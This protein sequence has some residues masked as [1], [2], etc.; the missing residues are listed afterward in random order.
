MNTSIASPFFD[1][2]NQV[3]QIFNPKPGQLEI[4]EHNRNTKKIK[5]ISICEP[6]IPSIL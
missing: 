2:Q 6:T 4:G 5:I 1:N 3:I